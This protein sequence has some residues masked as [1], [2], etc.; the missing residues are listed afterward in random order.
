MNWYEPLQSSLEKMLYRKGDEKPTKLLGLNTYKCPITRMNVTLKAKE[1][2][3]A[4]VE[5]P[6]VA[7]TKK[8]KKN[9]AKADKLPVAWTHDFYISIGR[10]LLTVAVLT[11]SIKGDNICLRDVHYYPEAEPK[12]DACFLEDTQW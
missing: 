2:D 4:E 5:W 7:K 11:D 3:D 9:E 10:N 6:Y 1:N 12:I 8:P